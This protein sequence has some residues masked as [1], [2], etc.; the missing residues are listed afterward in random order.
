MV[1]TG[2][3]KSTSQLDQDLRKS[4]SN[5]I[6][7]TRFREAITGVLPFRYIKYALKLVLVEAIFHPDR[8]GAV[9]TLQ[10]WRP[11]KLERFTS[12]GV[13]YP[14]NLAQ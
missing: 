2:V 3:P 13:E 1:Q 14:L 12:A 10:M 9:Q 5:K 4:S 8:C 6:D 7:S 11:Q